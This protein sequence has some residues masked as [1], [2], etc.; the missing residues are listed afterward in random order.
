VGVTTADF[1]GAWAN[2]TDWL[3]L[4]APWSIWYVTLKVAPVVLVILSS[5][6]L[7]A[8]SPPPVAPV[9]AVDP[10]GAADPVVVGGLA[11][12]ELQAARMAPAARAAMAVPAARR[13]GWAR[14]VLVLVLIWRI[15]HVL[16]LTEHRARDKLPPS[17]QLG[18]LSS[19]VRPGPD[20]RQAGM[21][22]TSRLVET[23]STHRPRTLDGVLCSGTRRA[24]IS[25]RSVHE[26]RRRADMEHEVTI[27][28]RCR[29]LWV[30]TRGLCDTEARCRPWC[31]RHAH[32]RGPYVSVE[33]STVPFGA[34]ST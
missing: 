9:V 13:A 32:E 26:Q 30:A 31:D 29:D 24:W 25:S 4:P 3:G 19:S 20:L 33:R 14:L 2:V 17:V 18:Q 6:A 34:T 7:R 21:R 8:L 10:A 5:T 27:N 11:D 28:C 12:P 1:G 16:R 23:S 22:G 15:V